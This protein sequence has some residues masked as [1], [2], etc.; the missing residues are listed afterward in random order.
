M[1]PIVTNRPVPMNGPIHS[2]SKTEI[3]TKI[4]KMLTYI[5]STYIY[6]LLVKVMEPI[7]VLINNN[8]FHLYKRVKQCYLPL[9]DN[10]FHI[11]WLTF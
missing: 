10:F 9:H 5:Y 4:S 2:K 11:I 1:H 8:R 3:K 7:K 6:T